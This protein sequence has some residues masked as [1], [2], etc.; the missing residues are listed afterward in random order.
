MPTPATSPAD[1]KKKGPPARPK[2]PSVFQVLRPYRGWIVLLVL[3]AF[4]VNGLYLVVPALVARGIDSFSTGTFSL[5]TVTTEFLAVSVAIFLFLYGQ[6]AVQTY[7]SELAAKDLRNALAAKISRQSNARLQ[8]LT[9]SVLL[10]NLT[11]DI[12]AVKLFVAQ[13]V[14][15]IVSSLFIIIGASVLLLVLHWKLAL[16]VL[17][18]IPLIGGTFF[19]VFRKVRVLF[20]AAQGVIDRLNKVINESILGSS[21]IRVIHSSALERD[22]FAEANANARDLGMKILRLFASMIPI[23]TFVSNLAVLT[24]LALGGRFVIAGSLSLGNFAAFNSYVAI[25]IFPIILIGFMS[26]VIAR[27]TA[28]YQRVKQ[29]LDLPD[30]ERKGTVAETLKG[31]I[32]FA[33]VTLSFGEKT[34]L[35]NVSFS[36]P[37]GTKTAIVGPTAAGKTQFLSLLIG[38]IRPTSGTVLLDGRPIDDYDPKSLHRQVGFVFQD[39]ILFHMTLRENI[40]FA[41]GITEEDLRKAV[42]TAELKDFIDTLPQGLE[43][44]VSERGTSLS[45]GQKQRVMLARALALNPRILL[46]DDFTA[47]VDA[48]TE[49]KILENVFK[50]YPNLTL[51]SVTQKVASA[52]KFDR[53]LLLMEGE[54]LA[55]GTHAQ[56][57]HSSPEYAQIAQS[58]RSTSHFEQSPSDTPLP[59]AERPEEGPISRN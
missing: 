18:I 49:Q 19:V 23:I 16:A 41:E 43:T 45:G 44:V 30:E 56:L 55:E 28:S 20:L 15:S 58:Q 7:V 38:L 39:S 1:D 34:A 4:A 24:I 27:A 46:L 22:K 54:L 3:L 9:P 32:A 57:L 11:S 52:E 48:R 5:P 26:G 51:V 13:A 10:T 47:R 53:I 59:G 33:D 42:E 21:L 35:K 6:S 14:A 36:L 2:G 40:A 50:N 17:T 29:V 12:D 8:E 25:L 37:G 31:D